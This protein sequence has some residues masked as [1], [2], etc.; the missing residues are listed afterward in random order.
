MNHLCL[1]ALISSEIGERMPPSQGPCKT[2]DTHMDCR[3]RGPSC[4]SLLL[5]KIIIG[6]FLPLDK[7]RT[8]EAWTPV[9][10][11]SRDAGHAS[12]PGPRSLLWDVSPPRAVEEPGPSCQADGGSAA[13]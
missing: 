6:G 11:M 7:G 2:E 8:Q 4:Y 3:G 5:F 10:K 1:G 12:C 13:A 9:S